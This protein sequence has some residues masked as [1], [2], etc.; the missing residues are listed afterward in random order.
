MTKTKSNQHYIHAA[1][2]AG[3]QGFKSPDMDLVYNII[4]N[5]HSYNLIKF[6]TALGTPE[7]LF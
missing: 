5:F 6:S 3:N 4:I 2:S 1:Q 7:V